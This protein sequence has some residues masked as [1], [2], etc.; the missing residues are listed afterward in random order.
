MTERVNHAIGDHRVAITILRKTTG[1]LL[2]SQHTMERWFVN[3]E[4]AVRALQAVAAVFIETEASAD[5]RERE[6]DAT[7]RVPRRGRDGAG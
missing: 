6:H 7:R 4:T 3:E 2:V 1:D 5:E